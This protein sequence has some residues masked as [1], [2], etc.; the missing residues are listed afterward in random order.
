ML[1]YGEDGK[2]DAENLNLFSA[3]HR[4]IKSTESFR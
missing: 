2:S 4:F 3:V 1:L